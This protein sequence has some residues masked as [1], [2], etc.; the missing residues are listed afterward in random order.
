MGIS[1]G[2]EDHP[3]LRDAQWGRRVER[4]WRREQRRLGKATVVGALV[5]G[6]LIAVAA[7]QYAPQWFG[8]PPRPVVDFGRP[9]AGTPY[10]SW[11]D[12]E[13]AVVAAPEHEQVRRAVIAA[14]IDPAE[15]ERRDG[16]AFLAL[17]PE[18][19]RPAWQQ[20]LPM[21]ATQLTPGTKLLPNGVRAQGT[22]GKAVD[23]E[24]KEVVR[25]DFRIA[26]A[27]APDDPGV[28][29]GHE[30]FIVMAEAR[31]DFQQ[32]PQGMRITD[33]AI[34]WH[35]AACGAYVSGL[36]APKFAAAKQPC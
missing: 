33:S 29:R 4:E 30:D 15:L 8:N 7:W 16:A 31:A 32:T 22:I 3:D 12:G 1:G 26:Y 23:G 35:N 18:A 6:A 36:V 13:R 17:F 2:I 21:L 20:M 9:F 27:F 34:R 19:A 25:A 24:G 10:E 14:R 5:V 28:I 11:A